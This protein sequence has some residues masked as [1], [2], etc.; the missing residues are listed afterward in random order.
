[1]FEELRAANA[2]LAESRTSMS[3]K[4][5]ITINTAVV[6]IQYSLL[7]I[8]CTDVMESLVILHTAMLRK[9]MS[10]NSKELQSYEL[11]PIS[12]TTKIETILVESPTGPGA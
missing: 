11:T 10:V 5:A 1:M 7:Q 6:D 8:S 4:I 3:M 2:A 9:L 12:S